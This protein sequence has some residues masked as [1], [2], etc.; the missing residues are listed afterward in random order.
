LPGHGSDDGPVTA[1]ADHQGRLVF[2]VTLKMADGRKELLVPGAQQHRYFLVDQV[3]P[4]GFI[5]NPKPKGSAVNA[6]ET[7]QELVKDRCG[8]KRLY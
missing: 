6:D 3:L 2:R 1:S 5:F 8:Q 4:L 7:V